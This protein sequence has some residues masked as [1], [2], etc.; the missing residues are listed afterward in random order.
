MSVL[1][2]CVCVVWRVLCRP[3]A[4]Q[5]R[6]FIFVVVVLFC[7]H[8]TLAVAQQLLKRLFQITVSVS[9]SHQCSRTVYFFFLLFSHL[10]CHHEVFCLKINRVIYR[11]SYKKWDWLNDRERENLSGKCIVELIS[12]NTLDTYFNANSQR[13]R[14]RGHKWSKMCH[15]FSQDWFVTAFIEIEKKKTKFG[16]DAFNNSHINGEIKIQSIWM[17]KAPKRHIKTKITKHS[18][19][20]GR[21]TDVLFAICHH[22]FSSLFFILRK[23]TTPEKLSPTIHI[24]S[25]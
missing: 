16:C 2:V 15:L 21:Q 13:V 12:S 11:Y 5:C 20:N 18:N 14:A 17:P 10:K 19:R 8:F 22:F 7:S 6:L 25:M 3:T 9:Q 24:W 1:C 23:P 4:D